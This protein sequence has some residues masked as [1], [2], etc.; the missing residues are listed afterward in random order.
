MR[1]IS[2]FYNYSNNL[3]FL[4]VGEDFI[5]RAWISPDHSDFYENYSTDIEEA[6]GTI[7]AIVNYVHN[8]PK[9]VFYLKDL[10]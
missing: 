2:L 8:N 1:D 5:T 3:R 6:S 10:K 9:L 7:N 4:R